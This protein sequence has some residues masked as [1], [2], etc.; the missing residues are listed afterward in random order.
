MPLTEIASFSRYMIWISEASSAR[1]SSPEPEHTMTETPSPVI[2]D[3]NILLTPVL[4][5]ANRTSPW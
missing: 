1:K 3:L 2:A 4:F 5:F